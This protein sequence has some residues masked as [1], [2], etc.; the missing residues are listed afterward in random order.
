MYNKTFSYFY[1]YRNDKIQKK[2]FKVNNVEKY[3]C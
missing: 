3:L 1:V 2:I